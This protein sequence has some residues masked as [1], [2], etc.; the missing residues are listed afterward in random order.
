MRIATPWWR[1]FGRPAT[2]RGSG[3]AVVALLAFLFTLG[4]TQLPAWRLIDLRSFD[5]LSTLFAPP[6]P[7]DGPVI[8]AIDE[9][10]FAELGLQ[11]PWPRE[12]HARLVT[13]LRAAGARAVGLDIIFAEPT[14]AASDSALAAALGPDVTVAA[15][16]TLIETPQADQLLRIEPLPGIAAS[17]VRIG[18]STVSLDADGT[19]RRL[20]AYEEGFARELLN[21]A[22]VPVKAH[23]GARLLQTYG[24]ARTYPTVSYYQ[25]LDPEAFLPPAFFSGRIVIVGLSL[26]SA[27]S[28]E[29]GG[30]DAYATSWTLRSSK[31]ISGAEIQATIL[32]NL[33]LGH[34]IVPASGLAVALAIAVAALLGGFAVFLGTTFRTVLTGLV[35]VLVI[36]ALSFQLLRF[37][38][39]YLAPAAPSLAFLLVL[40]VQAVRDFAAERRQRRSITRAFSQYLPP[41]LVER[42]AREPK[43]LSIGGEKRELTVLFC[44]LHGFTTIAEGMKE[45]P[46]RLTAL[47]NR[48]MNPLSHAIL[49]KGGTID[50]Y[51]GDAI[52]AFW[53]AP[54][55][56][57]DHAWHAVEASLA[58]LSALDRLNKDLRN[59]PA[60]AHDILPDIRIGIGINTGTCVVG[61][62]GSDHRFDYT[63]LGDTVNLAS[64]LEGLTR[65]YGVPV[66]LG[67]T[68]A[69][70]VKERVGLKIVDTVT[71]KGRMEAVDI[72]GLV[73][74]ESRL[75]SLRR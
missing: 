13:A 36:T 56:D 8:V 50:K 37:G 18:L 21:A 49:E 12:V 35:G 14:T 17:G 62:M 15:D 6:L 64:R 30:P 65:T 39:F 42:L 34:L 29:Q 4:L 61:N 3:I 22:E 66:I 5:Y 68:T 20:P 55:D 9:P 52:M 51:I 1:E 60:F 54:L 57:P 73:E 70:L 2:G 71:V 38:R 32:D 48:V 69:A 7:E 59:D 67:E 43:L 10:A 33:R 63:A 24:P 31:L 45:D 19:I 23:P 28:P 16:E 53:N 27:P 11:W 44:D 72:F 25:A 40:G 74:L 58:M 47:V 46:Q 75:V 26:Q 41:V